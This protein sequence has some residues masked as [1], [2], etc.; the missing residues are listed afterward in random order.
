MNCGE[1]IRTISWH[2]SEDFFNRNF[3]LTLHFE[4]SNVT[5]IK[6][7]ESLTVL[8][9]YRTVHFEHNDGTEGDILSETYKTCGY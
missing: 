3:E 1:K 7:M 9:V 4:T 2:I 6:F 8:I 5:N